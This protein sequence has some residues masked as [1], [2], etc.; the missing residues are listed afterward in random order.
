MR[1]TFSYRLP[2]PWPELDPES[3]IYNAMGL[4]ILVL[5]IMGFGG[6]AFGAPEAFTRFATVGLAIG[7]VAVALSYKS[8]GTSRAAAII[9]AAAGAMWATACAAALA[10]VP[11]ISIW[12]K[13]PGLFLAALLACWGTVAV[14]HAMFDL[15][16]LIYRQGAFHVFGKAL[17]KKMGLALAGAALICL[18]LYA[19]PASA[20]SCLPRA[21]AVEHHSRVWGEVPAGMGITSTGGRMAELFV[22]PSTGSWSLAST[23]VE[24]MTCLV[25]RGSDWQAVEP[26][27][28]GEPT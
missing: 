6:W 2:Y 13:P 1:E 22:N 20:A 19:A 11:A 21:A 12:S 15:A 16:A 26:A 28:Q 17:A 18:A 5:L 8:E 9:N 27:P 23:D 3:W 14:V 10:G 4:L 25:A 7:S 24:G